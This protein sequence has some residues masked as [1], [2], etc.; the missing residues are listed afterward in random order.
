MNGH[1]NMLLEYRNQS[2]LHKE[3]FICL[4][5]TF[6]YRSLTVFYKSFFRHQFAENFA[7]FNGGI[8]RKSFSE[9]GVPVVLNSGSSGLHMRWLEN[10]RVALRALA[11]M[12][13]VQ[14]YINQ[15]NMEKRAP[16]C[17]RFKI[18]SEAIK[19]PLLEAKLAFFQTVAME[20]E[21]FLTKFQSDGPL[22]P[23]LYESLCAVC[24]PDILQVSSVVN[25][26]DLSSNNLLPEKQ[27][28]IGFATQVALRSAKIAKEA[29]V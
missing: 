8:E 11:M 10:T 3:F 9:P 26:I 19:D 17:Q 2:G 21:G 20:L 14:E 7:N 1:F 27:I 4:F 12:P 18:V 28:D 23:R 24:K 6:Y 22:V 15:V 13:G 25:K 16:T 5:G 29:E